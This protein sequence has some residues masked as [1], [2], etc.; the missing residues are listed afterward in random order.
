VPRRTTPPPGGSHRHSRS[1]QGPILPAGSVRPAA[2]AGTTPRTPVPSQ[3]P[4]V[5]EPSEAAPRAPI[6]LRGSPMWIGLAILLVAGGGVWG[7]SR[8]LRASADEKMLGNT[9]D[10]E[11]ACRGHFCIKGSD[12]P[13]DYKAKHVVVV[14]WKTGCLDDDYRTFLE[15]L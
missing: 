12:L 6:T 9:P 10:Q 11:T 4:V 8:F 13:E 7:L 2:P 14:A 3:R 1:S 5:I 15:D